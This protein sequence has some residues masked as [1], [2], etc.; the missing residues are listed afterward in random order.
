VTLKKTIRKPNEGN[1]VP[2]F[3]YTGGE[4]YAVE[5]TVNNK[6]FVETLKKDEI[7]KLIFEKKRLLEKLEEED[8]IDD[9]LVEDPTLERFYRGRQGEDWH[10]GDFP[11]QDLFLKVVDYLNYKL[12]KVYHEGTDDPFRKTINPDVLRR[13]GGGVSIK[14]LNDETCW[15]FYFDS[16]RYRFE[17]WVWLTE[18]GRVWFS[19]WP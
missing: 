17:V 12:R 18:D 7:E 8:E 10:Y 14:H 11:R 13:D 16:D 6:I 9:D 19:D 4:A 15:E 3:T 2:S 1:W 5:F